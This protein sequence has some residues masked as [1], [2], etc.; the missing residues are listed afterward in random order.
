MAPKPQKLFLSFSG[1]R[2]SS[3]VPTYGNMEIEFKKL[4]SIKTIRSLE[5][6]LK[7]DYDFTD[8]SILFW[9][10]YET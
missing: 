7:K 6:R 4:S 1:Y 9:R 8:V 5:E 10:R 3:P 2:E